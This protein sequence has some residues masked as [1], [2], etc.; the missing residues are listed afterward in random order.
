MGL[1]RL[2]VARR[3]RERELFLPGL[4]AASAV[5]R[6]R[7]FPLARW[8]SGPT[9]SEG[10]WVLT[11]PVSYPAQ[12]AA[13]E[14]LLAAL[15][16]LVAG[17][18]HQRRRNCTNTAWPTPISVLTIRNFQCAI[19]AGGQ[20][21]QLQVGNRTAPGDQVFLRVIG[22]DG[23]FVADAGL[24]QA[25]PARGQ[26]LAQHRARGCGCQTTLTPSC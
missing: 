25:D 1:E 12:S 20:R 5:T 11:K 15:K 9:A 16:Q 14:A 2:P 8:K 22:V 13:I 18:A 6:S 19:T 17:H 21:W 10:S 3:R 23:V 7:S 24:A 4:Q 26:R